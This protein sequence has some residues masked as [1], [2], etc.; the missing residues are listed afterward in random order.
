MKR[1]S[2][3]ARNISPVHGSPSDSALRSCPESDGMLKLQVVDLSCGGVAIFQST[4][5]HPNVHDLFCSV[6]STTSAFRTR[7]TTVTF[8]YVLLA[9]D[10][11]K[12]TAYI[13]AKQHTLNIDAEVKR[14]LKNVICL[15]SIIIKLRKLLAQL[16]S[17]AVEMQCTDDELIKSIFPGMLHTVQ[18]ISETFPKEP[19]K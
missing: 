4:K 6:R 19:S 12:R 9:E 16:V 13:I 14:V 11:Q 5:H 2:N 8:S 1:R 7:P 15:K 18:G 17:Y 3:F 10:Y